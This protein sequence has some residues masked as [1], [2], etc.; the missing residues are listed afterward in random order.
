[1]NMLFRLLSLLALVLVSACGGGGGGAGTP[2]L[3]GGGTTAAPKLTVALSTDTVTAAAPATVTA[4]LV[5]AA[6]API[7][8]TVVA[9]ESTNGLGRFSAPS[10]L[11]DANG[12]ATVILSPANSNATGADTVKATATLSSG[13]VVGTVGFRLTATNVTISAFR[14]DISTISA[15]GQTA[16]TVTLAGSTPGTPVNIA[17]SSSCV[18]KGLATLTPT[19]ATTSTGTATFT[20]RDAGC[21]SFDAVDGIQASVTGTAATAT[22]QLTLTAPTASS[23]SFVS[24][25]PDVI[26]LRGSGFVENSNIVFQ[27]RDANGLGV[28]NRR[29]VLE[30]TTLAGGLLIDGGSVPVT[31]A[32]DS[33]GK[34]V[35]RVNAGTVPT[36]VRIRATL[37]NSTISTVSSSLAIAVGLPAQNNFSLSQRTINIEGYNRDGTPN[38]YT[39]IASDRLGNPV[40]EGTAINFVTEAGQ[41]Q[42]IATTRIA[43]GLSQAT[44]NFQTASP[45]PRDGRVTVVAYALGEESFL[46][47]NGNN[48]F[49]DGEDFQDLGDV[50]IDRL[51]NNTYNANVDQFIS[52]SVSG[53][54]ACRVATSPLLRL[55][56]SAPSRVITNTGAPLATCNAGWGRAYV[57]RAIQTVFSTSAASP[58]Y[59]TSLPANASVSNAA[60]CPR[61]VPLILG[62]NPDDTPVVAEFFPFGTVDLVRMPKEGTVNLIASD[63]NPDAYNP[64][65]AGTVITA[66]A[67]RGL[68]VQVLG[69]SPVPSTS[70]PT[71]VTVG[72]GFDDVTSSGTVTITFTSPAGLSTTFNQFISRSDSG[73]PCP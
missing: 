54:S 19:Q 27:V 12:T 33:E 4:T 71:G 64:V 9:F 47:A 51:F 61:A 5:N 62:Y 56:V 73:V 23:I 14:S 39:I 25:T 72:Y 30:P 70:T 24:A 21:G 10:A 20:Y 7:P 48:V 6:G 46:D 16:L 67:T 3:G 44:A 22:L 34:V 58:V 2:V 41:V 32:T 31:R 52:L 1:M 50:Y 29:V 28:P 36:P 69:G 13:E 66:V 65:A 37:E 38:T 17:L 55:D 11:T 60:L 35:V 18:A 49:D 42:A 68:A 8:A 15:Y 43:N 59:G 53:N 26:F 40:P 63:A 45:R 57:R